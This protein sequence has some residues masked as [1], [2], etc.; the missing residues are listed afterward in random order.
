MADKIGAI[1]ND[2]SF[3]KRQGMESGLFKLLERFSTPFY[4]NII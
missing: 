2:S 4:L 3:K 1:L